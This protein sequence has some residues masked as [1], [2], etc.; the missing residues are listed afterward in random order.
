[1][2]L[3]R[4]LAPA[5]A[6][7]LGTSLFG[8]L[9]GQT[10]QPTASTDGGGCTAPTVNVPV[11]RPL[12]RVVPI[13]AAE[14]LEGSYVLPLV[15][16]DDAGTPLTGMPE[17][18]V[19]LTFTYEGGLAFY[20]PCA[21]GGPGIEMALDVVTRDHGALMGGVAQVS[22][23]PPATGPEPYG[24]SGT[25]GSFVLNG[26]AGSVAGS[27]KQTDTGTRLSGT[28]HSTLLPVPLEDA[29]FPP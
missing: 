26:E 6:L 7:V 21:S 18:E 13:D 14:A 11:D 5:L 22:F 2:S 3:R 19:T 8:C 10:G 29:R 9:G 17:D 27:M 23:F 1:M 12:R 16:V 20:N 24:P 28:L 15:W 4:V 25:F